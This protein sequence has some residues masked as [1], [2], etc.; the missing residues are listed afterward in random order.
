MPTTG[1]GDGDGRDGWAAG[2][3]VSW[4]VPIV[5][6][7]ASV[8]ASASVSI[9]ASTAAEGRAGAPDTPRTQ[10]L[11]SDG[12]EVGAVQVDEQVP[13]INR[14]F[15]LGLD[16]PSVRAR[17]RRERAR[18]RREREERE[19][20]DQEEQ[21]QA[22]QSS[23]D[24][25]PID[26]DSGAISRNHRGASHNSSGGSNTRRQ[27]THA[28]SS[29]RRT[30]HR[31][32]GNSDPRRHSIHGSL[33]RRRRSSLDRM[34]SVIN[35]RLGSISLPFVQAHLVQEALG[36]DCDDDDGIGNGNDD[37]NNHNSGSIDDG[38]DN[39]GAGARSRR[40]SVAAEQ[41]FDA[42][43]VSFWE[44]RWKLVA[45]V[46]CA[47]V[48]LLTISLSITLVEQQTSKYP[49]PGLKRTEPPTASPSFDP[50]PT[51]AAVR[52]RG[53]V[54]CGLGE[55]E[56]ASKDHF[57]YHL[58]CAARGVR[59]NCQ[60][61]SFR[62]RCSIPLALLKLSFAASGTG[63]PRIEC[64]R[65]SFSPLKPQPSLFCAPVLLQC[66][67]IAAVI[68]GDPDKVEGV[69]VT[70][71]NRFEKLRDRETDVQIQL[72]THTLERE[73]R[74][75]T[76]GEGFTFSSP[77]Y[78]DGLAYMGNKSF[79]DC[80]EQQKRYAEC[81]GLSICAV[82]SSTHLDMLK[83]RFP[84]DFLVEIEHHTVEMLLDG[85][86]EVLAGDRSYMVEL[87]EK[88][89]D[90]DFVV[91]KIVTASEP[92]AMVTRK[93]EKGDREFSD[94]VNWVL[95]A[96]FYGEEQGLTKDPAL[97]QNTSLSQASDLD[98]MNA[99]YCVGNYAEILTGRYASYRH[100]NKIN[101]GTT[102]MVFAIPLGSVEVENDDVDISDTHLL[103]VRNK[104]DIACGC[105]NL[106]CGV[107]VPRDFDGNITESDGL[108]GM[109]VTYCQTLGAA[110]FNG[111]YD[112]I[113]WF[114]YSEDDESAFHALAN[115]TIDVLAGGRIHKKY[116]FSSPAFASGF[117][118]SS[119][120][121]FGNEPFRDEVSF[122]S[123]VTREDDHYFS[124][125][126]NTVVLATIHASQTK[127]W[128]AP[129]ISLFGPKF[130]W[131][132]KDAISFGKNYEQ[133]YEENFGEVSGEDRGRNALNA[134][135]P[136]INSFPGLQT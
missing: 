62:T 76:T 32:S 88:L 98:Y 22:S 130:T 116:D 31:S 20:R 38:D 120:Y 2:R 75:P 136:Q 61:G 119:P 12:T 73:V 99:V 59:S 42:T 85:D 25:H 135:G 132:L 121:Y 74:E 18:R 19:R 57:R 16:R 48:L 128:Q 106:R 4:S 55:K 1:G 134:G 108:V 95:Q 86:C 89:I 40:T 64:L 6:P 84:S 69:P 13:D 107:F 53:A 101:D 46:M 87:H 23:P 115:G 93:G 5:D 118:Y 60:L 111:F 102:G 117:Y 24:Q 127:G 131:A 72:E 8:S 26:S 56:I 110:L 50:R 17:Q 103:H 100:M 68:L 113:A 124:S 114:T 104:S 90:S 44:R 9:S 70:W 49:T 126:V 58:G 94:V 83:R 36:D 33:D 129:L 63:R 123:L 34:R 82:A 11:S 92:L 43:P 109:S 122:Y 97:C 41:I 54:R 105:G 29:D 65:C 81:A 96:L 37:D 80:A 39:H 30:S 133:I 51:L 112:D 28:A 78:Y 14:R 10:R 66:R 71:E 15:F 79:V 45:S 21:Q 27:T 77:Y 67:S 3:S 125:F 7:D 91:G 47:A 35:A 52:E